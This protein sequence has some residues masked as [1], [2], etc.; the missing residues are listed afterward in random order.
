L[1]GVL[2][3]KAG[4]VGVFAVG[5]SILVVDLVMRLLVIEKK[6]AN[7]YYAEDPNTVSDR[8]TSQSNGPSNGTPNNNQDTENQATD[9]SNEEM[10]LIGGKHPSDEYYKLR[11]RSEYP[12]L[13]R[14]VPILPCLSDPMLLTALLV[15]MV[16]ALLL[17]SFDSTIPTVSKQLFDFSSL[18]SGLLFIPLGVFDLI[19]GP[20]FGWVVDRYGTKPVAVLSYAF[21]VPALVCLRIPHQGGTDQIVIY[22]VILG[23]CGIG[24]AGIGAPSIVEA[25]AIVQ[26]YYDVNPEFFGMQ[27]PYAQLYGLSSMVFSLGL[28]V[29]PE[30]SGELRQKVGYGNMNIVLAGICLATSMLSFVFVGGK[31]QVLRRKPRREHFSRKRA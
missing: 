9:T 6:V 17:G 23:F 5:A 10:P 26:K 16:Q 13:L 2:Y 20:V 21:L 1:G 8:T 22:S 14:K 30:L 24:L 19:L 4:Y 29:G 18:Y 11:P 28:T 15:A 27:G 31:P 3:D 12:W 25:G 7:K